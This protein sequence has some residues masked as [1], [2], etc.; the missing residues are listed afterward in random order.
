MVSGEVSEVVKDKEDH[1]KDILWLKSSW[2]SRVKWDA[3]KFRNLSQMMVGIPKLVSRGNPARLYRG[4][5]VPFISQWHRS[6]SH[7][8]VCISASA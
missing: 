1:W 8:I 6:A 3:L 2:N 5:S 4:R 7:R